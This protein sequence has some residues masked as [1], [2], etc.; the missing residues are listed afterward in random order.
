MELRKE[1]DK[2]VGTME[3]F[4]VVRE[5]LADVKKMIMVSKLASS[6]LASGVVNS[7]SV[8]SDSPKRKRS[9][10][11]AFSGGV[12]KSVS[13]SQTFGIP[14]A[15]PRPVRGRPDRID[16][17]APPRRVSE[18]GETLQRSTV[19]GGRKWRGV[20]GTRSLDDEDVIGEFASAPR[21]SYVYVGGC[22]AET[23]EEG[24]KNYCRRNEVDLIKVET[25]NHKIPNRKSF[26]IEMNYEY[27]EKVLDAAFWL[28]G[29]VVRPFRLPRNIN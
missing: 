13:L 10:G 21:S 23:T 3:D 9:K 12:G 27:K 24:V 1:R 20:R 17:A 22:S 26:K 6:E 16:H 7:H 5:E 28:S 25:P 29:I 14:N 4:A 18:S 8:S 19:G 2:D 11:K 15:L